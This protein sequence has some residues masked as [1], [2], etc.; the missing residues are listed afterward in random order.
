MSL[1]KDNIVKEGGVGVLS[2]ISQGAR[3]GQEWSRRAALKRQGQ[4]GLLR[5]SL[6]A[7]RFF[8]GLCN[9]NQLR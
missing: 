4:S 5:S 3:R 2:K 6:S 9:A 1:V 8:A 7:T